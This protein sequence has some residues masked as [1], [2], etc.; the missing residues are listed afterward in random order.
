MTRPQAIK[1]LKGISYLGIYGGLLLPLMFIPVVI[2]P[3]VF[4]KLIYF[5]IIVGLTFPAY[6]ALAWMDPRY[7]PPK[8]ILYF[9]LLGYFAALALSVVFAVD[10]L[11]AWW[12]NQERM[13]GLFTLLHFLAWMTMTVG[14]LKTWEHW[15]KIL[16]YEIALS[17][18]MAIVAI[19]QKFKPDILL[20]PA[21]PRVGGLLDNP[22]YMAAYQIFNLFFIGLLFLKEKNKNWRIFYGAV[23]FLDVIA[24]ILAESRGALIGLAAGFLA[25]AIFIGFFSKERKIR[26]RVLGSI[27]I[28][29]AVYG[30][31]FAFRHEPLIA[32]SPVSRLLDFSGSVTTRL[33]AWNIAWE[34]F[35]DRPLTGWGL[36]NF[37]ILFN[38]K[39]NPESLRFGAYETWFD[40]AH[41]TVLDVLSM[42]GLVGILAYAFIYIALFYSIWRAYKKGW[43]DLWFGAILTALPVAYFVQNLFV[44]DHPAG[45]TMSYLLF[46]LVISASRGKFVGEVEGA[47]EERK[48]RPAPWIAFGVLQVLMLLFVWR[49]S[50]LPFKAS[51]LSIK[52]NS[53]I[54]YNPTRALEYM[55]QA[56]ATWTP[57]LDEQSFLLARN[58][59]GLLGQNRLQQI[60]N[61]EEMYSLAK[62]LSEE[63][64][65]RHP[66][67]THPRFIYARLAHAVSSLKPEEAKVAE[68]QYLAAIETSPKR[69]QLYDGLAKLYLQTGRV[70]EA[71]ALLQ[72]V[73]GLDAESGQGYWS[74]GL[75]LFYD[76]KDYAN[77]AEE[78]IKSQTV[79]YPYYPSS[80]QEILPLFDA[81]IVHGNK[82]ELTNFINRLPSLIKATPEIYGQIAMKFQL[83]NQ[84]DLRDQFL[85]IANQIDPNT[86][87][88]FDQLLQAQTGSATSSDGVQKAN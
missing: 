80:P 69:Q 38:Q 4:S 75:V 43:I 37:H 6:L 61:W 46:A 63:E 73:R 15:K 70:D 33:I 86:Q 22:I 88:A 29:F 21:G 23:A 16:N 30:L 10:P 31:L 74:Y 34:G 76:V 24:F 26:T 67:N 50:V 51:Q 20:F 55:K 47:T 8:H 12:G 28:L 1:I 41:N 7:R 9:G 40:R 62:Q 64:I 81:Y 79:A 14:L 77:G 71:L 44:F 49:T 87:Q 48:T 52:A 11:R 18:I 82:E 35:L 17:G 68:E 56:H 45:F 27:A 60:P 53:V 3:F 32:R 5:Q 84:L 39:Y 57:Y 72:K 59:I 13:N 85:E 25:F 58:F 65:A 36:D 66:R 2:F 54:A 78:I 83:I 42:T 19:I